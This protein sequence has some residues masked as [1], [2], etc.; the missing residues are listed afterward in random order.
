MRVEEI[1]LRP[2]EKPRP[3]DIAARVRLAVIA[4][5]A[6]PRGLRARQWLFCPLVMDLRSLE[7]TADPARTGTG[8][9]ALTPYSRY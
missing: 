4:S 3:E 5:A 2:D 7:A 8:P 6:A 9:C 1:P